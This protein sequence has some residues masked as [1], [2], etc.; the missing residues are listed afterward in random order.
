MSLTLYHLELP[1][2]H[3]FTSAHERITHR[4]TLLLCWSQAGSEKWVECPAFVSD[5]YYGY[6][7]EACWQDFDR[8]LTRNETPQ[9]N[10]VRAAITQLKEAPQAPQ[11]NSVD[12]SQV[13]GLETPFTYSGAKRVKLKWTPDS[14]VDSLVVIQKQ[15][16]AGTQLTLDANES[17]SVDTKDK[18][19]ALNALDIGFIEQPFKRK[20]WEAL[21]WYQKNVTTPLALDEQLNALEDL[22][23]AYEKLGPFVA[24]LKPMKLGGTKGFEATLAFCE[25]H[26][27]RCFVG[28]LL[29]TQLGRAYSLSLATDPRLTEPADLPNP[30]ATFTAQLCQNN[31]R[32]EN[33]VAYYKSALPLAIDI[34]TVE[35]YTKRKK[36][37][38]THLT[39]FNYS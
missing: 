36:T 8:A 13:I 17:F 33:S 12:I 34:A 4:E 30:S 5:A 6:S 7:L 9:L 27:L 19:L 22:E 20:D 35:A 38:D 18:L 15:L 28:G 37:Y 11:H 16:P 1:L 21:H 24:T 3:P 39:A 31:W 14:S 32:Y 10:L 25:T 26:N 2:T 29:E 23:E